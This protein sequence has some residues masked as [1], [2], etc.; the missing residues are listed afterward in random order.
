MRCAKREQLS[1]FIPEERLDTARLTGITVLLLG[2]DGTELPV[3]VPPNYVEGYRLAA[4]S[5]RFPGSR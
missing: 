4:R 5:G 1:V 2:R 3:F